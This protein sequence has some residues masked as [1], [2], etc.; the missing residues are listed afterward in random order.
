MIADILNLDKSYNSKE[1]EG[2][3][4][5][6]FPVEYEYYKK[7]FER[8]QDSEYFKVGN[9]YTPEVSGY[10]CNGPCSK[11]LV[12][13][14]ITPQKTKFGVIRYEIHLEDEAKSYGN[15]IGKY[16]CYNTNILIQESS[17]DAKYYNE[18]Y[19]FKGFKD[20]KLVQRAEEVQDGNK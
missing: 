7:V 17:N 13:T 18:T 3:M 6:C 1:F 10:G 8:S 16:V 15:H 20:L 19:Y 2:F 9:V 12:I 5:N 11:R 4:E 14:E